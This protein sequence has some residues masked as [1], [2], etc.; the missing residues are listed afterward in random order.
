MSLF[1]FIG[2]IADLA[3]GYLKNK[4]AE[5]NAVH[6]RKME[7]IK[8]DANWETKM[9]AASNNSI[10]DE[11]V[12]MTLLLPVWIIFFGAMTGNGELISR[13]E[14]GFTAIRAC[15]DEYWYLLFIGCTAAF[16]VKGADKLMTLRGK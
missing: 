1:N 5:K 14:Y 12:L 9:A 15:P 3:G 10:K 2:P 6:E 13:V 16:G 8:N 7:V 11:L 4:A